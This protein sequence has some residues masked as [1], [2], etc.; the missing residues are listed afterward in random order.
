MQI[1]LKIKKEENLS[2][3]LYEA[4]VTLELNLPKNHRKLQANKLHEHGTKS[5]YTLTSHIQ[6][7]IYKNSIP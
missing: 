4:N 7:Y 2:N 5:F 1:F 3:S 6:K